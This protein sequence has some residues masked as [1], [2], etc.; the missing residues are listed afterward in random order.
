MSK[1][2]P[3]EIQSVLFLNLIIMLGTSAMQQ[4]G[5]APGGEQ[6]EINLEGAQHFIDTLEVLE[7]KTRGNLSEDEKR[8]LTNTLT[9]LRM[10]YVE[11]EGK[12]KK[13][14]KP[15]TPEPEAP[16]LSEENENKAKFRK[17]YGEI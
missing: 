5:T 14:E 10:A 15:K 13:D 3:K 16:K 11:V 2:D 4:L 12:T 7:A 1:P 6:S 9:S 17:S 8:L